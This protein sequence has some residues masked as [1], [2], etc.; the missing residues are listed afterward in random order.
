MLSQNV[1]LFRSDYF[2]FSLISKSAA[3]FYSFQLSMDVTNVVLVHSSKLL[4][5]LEVSSKS[6]RL[7]ICVG[8][9]CFIY[10]NF[11]RGS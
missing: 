4:L 9:K 3:N 2:E 1:S 11:L 5:K 6:K 8:G 10:V 7:P